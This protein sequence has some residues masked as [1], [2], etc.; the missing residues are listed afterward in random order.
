M[1]LFSPVKNWLGSLVGTFS[2]NRMSRRRRSLRRNLT[3]ALESRVVLAAPVL[4]AI[5]NKAVLS[6]SPLLVALNGSDADNQALTFEATITAENL[7][8]V[9]IP[10]DQKHVTAVIPQGNRSMKI[11]VT[12]FGTMTFQLFD[13][14]APRVTNRIGALADSDFYNGLKFHRVV[15]NFVIQGGDPLGNGTG[16]SGTKFDDQFHVDLQHNQ[17]GIL[18][19]AKSSDDTNDSQFFITE[20]PQR[21]LDFNHS[22]FGFLTTGESVRDAISNTPV[23]SSVPNT[24]VFMNDVSVFNDTQNGVLMLKVPEGT[25][26]TA[27]VNVTV[28]DPNGNVDTKSFNITITADTTN[29][30]PFLR[31]VPKLR[32]L[33]NTPFQ[34][35][36]QGV[37]VEG[38]SVGYVG[39]SQLQSANVSVPQLAPANLGYSVGQSSGG[40][41]VNPINGLTGLQPFTVAAGV[42]F[43]TLDY[44]V[45]KIDIVSAAGPLSVSGADHPA[46]NQSN[47]GKPDEFRIKARV[48]NIQVFINNALSYEVLKSSITTL[49]LN[50]SNDADV[51]IIDGSGGDPL[52][53]G[54]FAINGGAGT[55]RVEIM[56]AAVQSVT[57]N[58]PAVNRGSMTV[59][60]SVIAYST[61]ESVVDDLIAVNRTLQYGA[62][63]SS[64]LLVDDEGASNARSRVT[65][66]GVLPVTFTTPYSANENVIPTLTI[67]AGGGDDTVN[68]SGGDSTLTRGINILGAG[69]NDSLI[70]GARFDSL[71]GGAGHDKLFGGDGDDFLVG[72]T[73]NDTLDGQ[74]GTD[75]ISETG[76]VN[77][78]L[79]ATTLTGLGTDGFSNVELGQIA[80]LASANLIDVS[81]SPFAVQIN[82]GAG[83]DTIIG[84]AFGDAFNGEDGADSILGNSGN[85]SI[86]GGNG[87]DTVFGGIGNDIFAGGEGDD[88]LEGE[89]GDDTLYGNDGADLLNGGAGNDILN[90]GVGSDTLNGSSGNDGL[91][92]G[93][94]DDFLNGGAGNDTLY[95]LLGNDSLIGGTE[96]DLCF[97]GDGNDTVTGQTGTDTLVGGNGGPNGVANPSDS[98]GFDIAERNETFDFATPN[99]VI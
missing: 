33:V 12:N 38:N 50:G 55:D 76:D 30:A 70:G 14:L 2:P 5:T 21:H 83:N 89:A 20:G 4:A 65:G 7:T 6:G 78:T 75:T 15:N 23:T 93:S 86:T 61:V 77:F 26:G 24:A 43:S 19:M 48:N 85:D 10:T 88:R 97:G 11:D 74:G 44:Q 9:N 28:R 27:T 53:S 52:P 39:Q 60:G 56:N 95:G 42:T 94:D 98:F 1:K 16:G 62:A 84:S 79:G 92:G 64:L 96:N 8:N 63:S 18:S 31:D 46:I 72:G 22:I 49:T 41:S 35:N 58:I 71:N 29:S 69:G 51:F 68:A 54:G 59:D 91:S 32:T 87:N 34:F 57:H 99:W 25:T 37:D 40:V 3:E 73:G 36:L 17:T 90:G 67:N 13:D 82:A 66:A 45:A 81:A 47:D 80:T